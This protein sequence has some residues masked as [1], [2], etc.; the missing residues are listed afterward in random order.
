MHGKAQISGTII[1]GDGL[2]LAKGGAGN[3]ES[4]EHG[5]VRLN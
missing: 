1:I 4:V 5:G 2:T 3:V